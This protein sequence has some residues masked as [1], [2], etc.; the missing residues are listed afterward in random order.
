MLVGYGAHLVDTDDIARA[1]TL[2]GG[3]AMAA[4]EAEF[5]AEALDASGGLN[6]AYMRRLAFGD[7]AA[8]SRLEA[9]LHPMIS[10]E[11]QRRAA[12]GAGRPVLFD[13]PLLA[14]SRG[15]QPWRT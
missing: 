2:P 10:E 1:L 14:E 4:L 8:K 9:I 6:R 13:V 12:T 11:A 3:A 15:L 5:G 7:A